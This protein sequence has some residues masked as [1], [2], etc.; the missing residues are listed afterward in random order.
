MLGVT[1]VTVQ[2]ALD[3]TKKWIE[4][5][6][7]MSQQGCSLNASCFWCRCGCS[8]SVNRFTITIETLLTDLMWGMKAMSQRGQ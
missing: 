1:A 5:A 6:M 4:T 2:Y 8:R 3:C 7:Q